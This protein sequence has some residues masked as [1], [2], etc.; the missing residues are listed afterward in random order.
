MTS[1]A[2]M[3]EPQVKELA[4][5]AVALLDLKGRVTE[6]I[7]AMH[8]DDFWEA[9]GERGMVYCSMCDGVGH[10]QPGYGPCPLE[11]WDGYCQCGGQRPADGGAFGC[12]CGGS[13]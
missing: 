5:G 9:W 3:T 4:S 1:L 12:M 7:P 11:V 2:E 13:V 6:I 10:G 8:A